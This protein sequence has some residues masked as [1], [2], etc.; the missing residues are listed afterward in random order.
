MEPATPPLPAWRAEL[1]EK[2]RAIRARRGASSPQVDIAVEDLAATLDTDPGVVARDAYSR[3]AATRLDP[4]HQIVSSP[5]SGR[6]PSNHI[7]EA[8]LTRVKRASE[9]ASRAALPKIEP[10]R[11]IQAGTQ[12][13]LAVDRQATARALEPAPEIEL[14]PA[15][16]PRPEIVQPPIITPARVETSLPPTPL[17]QTAIAVESGSPQESQPEAAAEQASFPAIDELE[18]LDYLE[19]EVRKVERAL[20]AQ[21]LRN[22]SPSIFTHVV[23]GVVDLVA[24]AVSCAPFLAIIRIAD[25]SFSTTRTMVAAGL[26]VALTSFF[27]LTLTQCL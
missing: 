26:M 1:S 13:S 25:G 23:I 5:A 11:P 10:A 12:V 14:Q 6:R 22:E 3:V 2:V 4:S 19:A 17:N 9:N 16:A 18:P 15:P 20:G 7:V 24:L 27:Y 21:F 8:A